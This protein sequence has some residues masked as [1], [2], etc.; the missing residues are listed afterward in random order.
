M[1]VMD[2]VIIIGAGP[3]GGNTAL[4]LAKMGRSVRIIE[5]GTDPGNKVCTGIIGTECVVKYPPDPEVIYREPI[6]ATVTTAN[7]KEYHFETEFPQALVVDRTRYV[8][9]FSKKA[10]DLGAKVNLGERVL[11]INVRDDCVEVISTKGTWYARLLVIASGFGTSLLSQV[12]ID[13][14]YAYMTGSQ[15]EVFCTDLESVKLYLDSVNTPGFFSWVTPTTEKQGLVGVIADKNSKQKLENFVSHLMKDGIIEETCGNVRSWG[16]PLHPIDRTYAKRVLVVGDAA[17]Q[18]KPITGGGIYY[19]LLCGDLAANVVDK[20]LGSNDLSSNALAEY[21]TLWKNHIG[22]EI[23]SAYVIRRFVEKIPSTIQ[24]QLVRAA[25]SHRVIENLIVN[26][27][28]FDEHTLIFKAM[29][30]HP[31]ISW[32]FRKHNRNTKLIQDFDELGDDTFQDTENELV[33]Y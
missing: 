20:C 30:S 22:K 4:S 26:K 9:S 15:I 27:G 28:M 14:N 1:N 24:S 7:G 32:V 6:S 16:I 23:K 11:S 33:T 12:G 31:A 17:G 3:A 25:K 19:A 29:F 5:A 2:D 21:E 10:K 8:A 18:I 13:Q